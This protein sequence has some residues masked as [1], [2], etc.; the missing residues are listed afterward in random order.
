MDMMK[1]IIN[2]K[3]AGPGIVLVVFLISAAL[4]AG[5]VGPVHPPNTHANIT[6]QEVNEKAWY[7]E[8]GWG[9]SCYLLDS[10]GVV[11]KVAGE[12]DCIRFREGAGKNYSIMQN[13][14]QKIVYAERLVDSAPTPSPAITSAGDATVVEL[15]MQDG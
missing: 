5:C 4:I 1:R 6:V 11:Y 13:Y 2:A 15:D 3:R 12:G 7:S 14:D 9:F 10:N 8:D